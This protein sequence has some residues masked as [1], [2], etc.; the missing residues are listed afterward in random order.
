VI[1]PEDPDA[2]PGEVP[3]GTVALPS[4]PLKAY[5]GVHIPLPLASWVY[6]PARWDFAIVVGDAWQGQGLGETLLRS[7]MRAAAG[8]G[9]SALTGITLTTNMRMIAL[10]RKLGFEARR[11]HDD[12]SITDLCW[13]V[14]EDV[15]LQPPAAT[16]EAA[17]LWGMDRL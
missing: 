10:A 9:V 3:P 15:G 4:V 13:Y 14:H 2:A 11:A 12:A 1:G 6:D 5:P 16:G 7:L 8:H 17:Y